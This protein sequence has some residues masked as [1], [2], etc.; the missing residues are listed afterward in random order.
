MEKERDLMG[1]CRLGRKQ[2]DGV[3]DGVRDMEGSCYC[4]AGRWQ[5]HLE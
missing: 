3:V 5:Q 4:N 1:R 2:W